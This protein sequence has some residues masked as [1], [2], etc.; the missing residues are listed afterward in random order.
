MRNLSPFDAIQRVEKIG[1]QWIVKRYGIG[2][3]QKGYAGNIHYATLELAQQA[4]ETRLVDLRKVYGTPGRNWTGKFIER[5][6][7]PG[8]MGTLLRQVRFIPLKKNGKPGVT[9]HYVHLYRIDVRPGE[10]EAIEDALK[11]KIAS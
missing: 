10:I 11:I 7:E 8:M 9:V 2:F 6:S 3:G 1:D 4:F 5:E